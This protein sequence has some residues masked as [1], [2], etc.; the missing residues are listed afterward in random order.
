MPTVDYLPVANNP[1]AFVVT[2]EEWVILLAPGGD[3]VNG[4]PSG[5]VLKERFNKAL[6]QSSMVAAALAQFVAN[7]TDEDVLDDGNLAALVAL[8]TTAVETVANEGAWST[9]DL[10]ITMKNV[11]DPGWILCDDGTIGDAASG[12][13]HANA[14]NQALFTLLWNNVSDTWA[15]VVTGRGVSAAADWAAHKRITLTKMLGRA[16]AISGSGSGLTARALGQNLGEETHTILKA[17]LPNYNLNVTDP[18]HAH[19]TTFDLQF[20]AGGSAPNILVVPGFGVGSTSLNTSSAV[21]NVTVALG[22]SGSGANVMQPTSFVNV[23]IKQ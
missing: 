3:L 19:S 8:L 20:L 18:G 14:A 2:Q 17:E 6:R 13:T 23:M 15:P 7:A 22:G 4:F 21:T 10:K 11:A 1:G 12:A 5:I 16:L 9:G